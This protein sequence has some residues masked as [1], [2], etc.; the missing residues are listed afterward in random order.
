VEVA[1]ADHSFRTRRAD[2]TTTAQALA[3]VAAAVTPWLAGR[4]AASGGRVKKVR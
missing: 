3:A 1:D 4:V 2:A